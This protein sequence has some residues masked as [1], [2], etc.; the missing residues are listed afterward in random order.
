MK[1]RLYLTVCLLMLAALLSANA[2]PVSAASDINSDAALIKTINAM[3]GSVNAAETALENNNR[4]QATHNLQ[5]ALDDHARAVSM[6]RRNGDTMVVP[7]YRELLDTAAL[8]KGAVKK[9]ITESTYVAIDLNKSGNRLQAA[10]KALDAGNLQAAKD[11]LGAVG[12]DL[13]AVNVTAD[14]PLLTA[15]E[16]LA[17]ARRDLQEHKDSQARAALTQ[18]SQALSRYQSGNG[19]YAAQAGALKTQLQAAIRNEHNDNSFGTKVESWWHQVT[20]WFNHTF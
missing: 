13:V 16:N 9:T 17:I 6:A 2:V 15:R 10:K 18:A 14:R 11:T 8:W 3:F 19:K 7:L 1:L 4:S 20:Q 5:Q 12:S